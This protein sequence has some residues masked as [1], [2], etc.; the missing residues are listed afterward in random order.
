[1]RRRG[2]ADETGAVMERVKT[3]MIAFRV[4]RELR[5]AVNAKAAERG[6]SVSE[7]VRRAL[8]RYVRR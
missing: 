8:T 3:V 2:G 7:V 6:E 1:M 4:P 5:E